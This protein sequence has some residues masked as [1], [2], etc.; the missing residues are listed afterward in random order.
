MSAVEPPPCAMQS[1][2]LLGGEVAT[3]FEQVALL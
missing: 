1:V 3:D 2:T